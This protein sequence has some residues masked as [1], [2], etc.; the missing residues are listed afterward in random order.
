[1]KHPITI[2]YLTIEDAR[3]RRPWS[4]THH[5]LLKELEQH[6]D[7]VELLGPI[8]EPFAVLACKVL[9]QLTLRLLGKRFNYRASLW[10]AKS[11]A[12]IVEQRLERTPVDVIMAPAGLSTIAYLRTSTPI[13]Y[14]N[15]R[16]I[17]GALEYHAILKDLFTWSR[18]QSLVTERAALRNASLSV[19][20]SVWA[21]D[22]AEHAVPDVADR[23]RMIP[24][25][26]NLP[27]APEAI[28]QGSLHTGTLKLLFLGVN[29]EEKGGPIAYD[30]L[31][32]LK[33][34]GVKVQLVVCGCTPPVE[35]KD[36]DLLREGFLDKNKPADL[37]RLQEHLRTA[38]LLILPTR[39]EAYGIVFCEAAAYGLPVLASRTG[40]VPTIV[41]EGETGYLFGLEATG[42]DYAE[43][44]KTL[45][46]D[47]EQIQV[48]R[49][50]ARKRFDEVLNWKAFVERLL[51]YAEEAGLVKSAR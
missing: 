41:Q 17:A 10:V 24:F 50:R 16:A 20:S 7:R 19:F 42:L 1:M 34:A 9:N 15:D 12:R 49:R 36:P 4:G 18:E 5:F 44:I 39:F 51:A 31:L 40:G 48:M 29:W 38:D 28:G 3:D 47:R 11:Y 6:V 26:A 43:R 14:V 2:G 37:A 8:A 21:A 13:I 23:V 46:V 35:C 32:A 25:G 33:Q 45:L 30:T 22:A 27:Q